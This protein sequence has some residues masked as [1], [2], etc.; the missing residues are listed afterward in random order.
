MRLTP[1]P[2]GAY[3]VNITYLRGLPAL[4]TKSPTN[5]L[6]KASPSCYLFGTLCEAS[7]YIGHDDRGLGWLQRRDAAFAALEQAD[8]KARWGGPL[9]IRADMPATP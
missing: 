1:P 9:R 2:D 5:W 4:S 3:T 7:V 6:L 8:L